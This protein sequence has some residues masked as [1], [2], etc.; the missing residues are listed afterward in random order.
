ME[1]IKELHPSTFI[2]SKA[3][4]AAQSCALISTPVPAEHHLYHPRQDMCQPV[5]AMP[6][7]WTPA[8]HVACPPHR[9]PA[10]PPRHELSLTLTT[11]KLFTDTKSTAGHRV[12][13]TH[14]TRTFSLSHKI[15]I[16]SPQDGWKPLDW[17]RHFLYAWL[18]D[19]LESI[20]NH[21]RGHPSSPVKEDSRVWLL[22]QSTLE[23]L[24]L[25]G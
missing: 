16:D 17:P 8:R 23:K 11:R 22:R 12:L 21:S 7:P 15:K 19:R 6:S 1:E 24:L 18:G 14:A 13:Q 2:P 4:W 9:H 3:P 10:T 20:V 25:G 5:S